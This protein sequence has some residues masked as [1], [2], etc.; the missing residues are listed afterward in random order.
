MC[1]KVENHRT[2]GINHFPIAILTCTALISFC[3]DPI[4]RHASNLNCDV[5]CVGYIEC[6]YWTYRTENNR[7]QVW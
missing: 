3:G 7:C 1:K 4:A 6:P 5:L 2:I